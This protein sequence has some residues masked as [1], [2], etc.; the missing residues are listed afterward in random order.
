[1]MKQD[2]QPTP[3]QPATPYEQVSVVNAVV[4]L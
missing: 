1:M 2:Q 3:R 4:V